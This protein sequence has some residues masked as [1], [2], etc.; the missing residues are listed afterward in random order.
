MMF[1]SLKRFLDGLL[2]LVAYFSQLGIVVGM[3]AATIM[4]AEWYF[5]SSAFIQ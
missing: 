4:M 1:D 2:G 3:H 5:H